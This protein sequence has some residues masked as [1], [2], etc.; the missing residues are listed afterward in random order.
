MMSEDAGSS[1]FATELEVHSVDHFCSYC[2]RLLKGT[3]RVIA[4]LKGAVE[5]YANLC[6]GCLGVHYQ[7][8]DIESY[9]I[10]GKMSQVVAELDGQSAET[11]LS[12]INLVER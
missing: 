3:V 10:C 6:P 8:I 7:E 11:A 9:K 1:G 4:K 2:K 5:S 12:C